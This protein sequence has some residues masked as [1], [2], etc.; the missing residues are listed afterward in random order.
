MADKKGKATDFASCLLNIAADFSEHNPL[1]P[2]VLHRFHV[3][4]D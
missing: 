3:H 4:A 2:L 1:Q